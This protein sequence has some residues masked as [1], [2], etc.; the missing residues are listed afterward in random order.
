M[1]SPEVNSIGGDETTK[2]PAFH[3]FWDCIT[4]TRCA[5]EI[6]RS[7]CFCNTDVTGVH[8]GT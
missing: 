6:L 1:G 4:L 8:V 5:K 2:L 3:W 7:G